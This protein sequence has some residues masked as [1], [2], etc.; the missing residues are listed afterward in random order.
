MA[1]FE[2]NFGEW[3][4]QNQHLISM[5]GMYLHLIV[6]ALF[7][8]YTGAHASLSRPSSA[9]KPTKDDANPDDDDEEEETPQA[10]EGLTPKDAILFPLTAGIVL[11]GLYYLIKRYGA[12]VINTFLGIYF[13]VIGTYSVGKLISDT[14]TTVAGIFWPTYYRSKDGKVWKVLDN[15]RKV[16]VV[17]GGREGESSQTHPLMFGC[18][19]LPKQLFD[20]AWS[21]R[22]LTKEKY[23]I[24]AYIQDALSSRFAFTPHNIIASLLGVAAISYSLFVDKP[25]W[26]TNLQGFA[27]CYGAMQLMSPTT[28]TTGSLILSG[29]FCYDIWAVFFTPLMVTVAKN[30]DVPI[31]L[32]FPRPEDPNI[33]RD[34]AAPRS[35][36]MLGLGDIVLPGLMIGLALRFDLYMFYLR[37]Q[38]SLKKAK[39]DTSSDSAME[40]VE[41]APYVPVSGNWAEKWYTR[42]ARAS[43]LPA[44]LST[45]FPK[46]Y[47]T[48]SL[49]GYVAGMLATLVVMSYWQHA[50]PALLYLVPGVL[51]SLW[52]TALFRGEREL[53]YQ[54]TEAITAEP[55]ED[56]KEVEKKDEKDDSDK[57][58]KPNKV[59]D[60]VVR[61]A[62][63]GEEVFFSFTI[64]NHS[65]KSKSRSASKK[66]GSDSH[67]D[68]S[69]HG[70]L[71]QSSSDST[72]DDT[73]M[74]GS[75]DLE[76]DRNA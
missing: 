70:K 50:Q 76:G 46:P 8:I 32:V 54:F 71:S 65:T 27:V 15:E 34:E 60:E 35:Y 4:S 11:S 21:F 14:W 28:F 75:I 10:M 3:Y 68:S 29:L 57:E 56:E 47:F 49:V 43:D 42:G 19:A 55:I 44:H 39:S 36:S 53:M 37:K 48:A 41:K 51:L 20:L 17:G 63:V 73:V 25:W 9:T 72:E 64:S 33:P 67:G 12:G 58:K 31:K 40:T 74:V 2:F 22:K 23:L 66:A 38:E 26:L 18:I 62:D 5:S 7:P 45:S 52:G 24:K 59:E 61:P 13:S 69:K 16:V 6:S 1:S 30:L